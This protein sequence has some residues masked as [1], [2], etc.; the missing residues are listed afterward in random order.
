MAGRVRPGAIRLFCDGEVR[1]IAS[2]EHAERDE[3]DPWRLDA[4]HVAARLGTDVRCGLTSAEAQ[5]RRGR[6]GPN[7]LEPEAAVPA[8]R[9]LL[10]QFA[11]PLVYLLL[12]AVLVSVTAWVAEGAEGVPYEALVIGVILILNAVLGYVQEARAEQAV[13][14]LHRMA[15]VTATVLRDGREERIA[16]YERH[17]HSLLTSTLHELERLQA[18][19]EGEP[20]PPPVVA[21][22]NVTVDPAPE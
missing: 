19:R 11:N 8:W 4:A 18:R 15:A 5:A 3:L 21:D 9:K 1:D 17:L 20:V 22:V 14:A 6:Y 10:S 16:K 7:E 12:A 2:D 13:A